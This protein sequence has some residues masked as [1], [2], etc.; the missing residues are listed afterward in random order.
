MNRE[1]VSIGDTRTW[2]EV[3]TPP[4]RRLVGSKWVYKTK[5]DASGNI[6]KF[7]A[8]IVAQGFS[9]IE[10]IDY[11]DTFSPVARLTSLRL[12]L[13]I[14]AIQ[15][16]QLHQMDADT[17]FL[18]GTLSKEI[19]MAFPPGY[20]QQDTKA[21]GLCLIKSLHGLKQSLRVW[22]KLISGY[23]QSIGFQKV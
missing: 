4:G 9:Q 1:L 3:V 19:Y 6:A 8:R 13:A 21:M 5:R 11:D 20:Q 16:L 14:T 7:K 17:A 2:K 10:G 22:W 12:L 23:L 18:N 15:D